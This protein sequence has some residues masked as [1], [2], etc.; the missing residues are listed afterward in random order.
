M[1][2]LCNGSIVWYLLYGTHLFYG[3]RILDYSLVTDVAPLYTLWD[4]LGRG[5]GVVLPIL[6]SKKIGHTNYFPMKKW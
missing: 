2:L 6:S 1:P 3:T 4:P 5:M